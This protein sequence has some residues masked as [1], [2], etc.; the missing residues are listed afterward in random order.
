MTTNM[1]LKTEN[2]YLKTCVEIHVGEK[3]CENM[4]N[5]I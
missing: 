3:V 2:C 1:H 5:V 4:C